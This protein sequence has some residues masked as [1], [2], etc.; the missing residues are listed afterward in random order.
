MC[1]GL[2]AYAMPLPTENPTTLVFNTI[3]VFFANPCPICGLWFSCNNL[4]LT[5]CS[6]LI[7]H[8][9]LLYIS[10]GKQQSVWPQGVGNPSHKN[11]SQIGVSIKSLCCWIV[12]RL[13][14]LKNLYEV[15][16]QA[17]PKP[18]LLHIVN[19]KLFS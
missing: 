17:L 10:Q 9:V 13:R 4:V 12:Q 19:T 16:P 8:F 14:G 11:R 1:R 6:A 7:T 2:G 5:S 18:Y 15:L 3:G